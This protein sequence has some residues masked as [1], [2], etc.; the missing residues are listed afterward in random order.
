MKSF[1][2]DLRYLKAGVDE[3]E[4]YLLS[5]NLYWPL[6]VK[7]QANEPAFPNLTLGNLLLSKARL[8]ARHRT[9]E[10]DL[11]LGAILPRLDQVRSQ[12]RAAWNKKAARSL[13]SRL[14]TW[15][16]FLEEYRKAPD[17]HYDRYAYEVGRRVMLD[18][19]LPELGAPQEELTG[20]LSR[21]D[22]LLQTLLLPGN[23]IWDAEL[24]GG[25]PPADFWY[26]YGSLP[27]KLES[28]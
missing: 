24:A 28:T 17:A 10:Q 5:E 4:S 14:N 26:L 9:L 22:A 27:E 21:L 6:D 13:H 11:Q 16:D 3:L 8:L 7:A 1:D 25:F 12:W 2:Y 23:F 20:L 19:L 18:L 15:R